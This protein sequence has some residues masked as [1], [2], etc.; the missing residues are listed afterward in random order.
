MLFSFSSGRFE[1]RGRPL[2]EVPRLAFF[3]PRTVSASKNPTDEEA[4]EVRAPHVRPN[5]PRLKP[6]D[7]AQAAGFLASDLAAM[8][9]GTSYYVIDGDNANNQSCVRASVL[10]SCASPQLSNFAVS[11]SKS[12]LSRPV[13]HSTNRAPAPSPPINQHVKCP[14]NSNWLRMRPL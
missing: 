1:N 14:G 7:L 10:R 13:K 3:I 4:A 8:V 11:Y 9:T 6:E 5:M 12:K 2:R